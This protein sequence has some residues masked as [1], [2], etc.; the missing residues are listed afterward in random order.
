M[1]GHLENARW[2]VAQN[3]A[4]ISVG[5]TALGMVQLEAGEGSSEGTL[6][7]MWQSAGSRLWPDLVY[8]QLQALRKTFKKQQC[9]AD[10]PQRVQ[11]P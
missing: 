6:M 11:H 9:R 8:R 1:L 5:G 7:M 10:G 4:K 2:N 3:T